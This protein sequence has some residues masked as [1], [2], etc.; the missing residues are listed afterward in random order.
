LGA[1]TA[2]IGYVANNV[3]HKEIMTVQGE[4]ST[5]DF[6]FKGKE[7]CIGDIYSPEGMTGAARQEYMTKATMRKGVYATFSGAGIESQAVRINDR[8]SSDPRFK[9]RVLDVTNMAMSKA[10]A[11]PYTT[12]SKALGIVKNATVPYWKRW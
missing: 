4:V 11:L 1:E 12:D 7:T 6:S 3:L 5:Y 10:K 9:N 8:L 2:A